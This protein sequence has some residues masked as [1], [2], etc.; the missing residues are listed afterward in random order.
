VPYADPE[1]RRQY[2]R[3]YKYNMRKK[4]EKSSPLRLFKVYLCLKFPNMT[5][6][7]SNFFNGFLITDNPSLQ[8]AVENHILFAKDIFP[9]SIDL[10]VNF[11]STKDAKF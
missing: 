4:Q 7:G 5:V 11:P 3:Q 10:S 9:L 1:K 6:G 2:Q 8:F